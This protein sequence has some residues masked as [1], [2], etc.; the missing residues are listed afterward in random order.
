MVIHNEKYAS[1]KKI[2][3]TFGVVLITTIC[4]YIP[5]SANFLRE[6][7]VEIKPLSAGWCTLLVLAVL[8][9]Y[10]G[11][12]YLQHKKKLNFI[13]VSDEDN[14][15]IVFRFYHIQLLMAK[16]TSYKIPFDA[17]KKYEIVNDGNDKNLILYQTM[18]KNQG[19][20]L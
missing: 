20:V 6:F 18:G 12:V 13:Y 16:C 15:N 8:A 10:A 11:V 7:G 1:R 3:K 17:F 19:S 2:W 5:L 4:V 14:Q 9:I